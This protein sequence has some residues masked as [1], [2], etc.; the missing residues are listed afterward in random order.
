MNNK[1]MMQKTIITKMETLLLIIIGLHATHSL[2][3]RILHL[4]DE[5]LKGKFIVFS[6]IVH[7]FMRGYRQCIISKV[8]NMAFF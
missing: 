1:A 2:T 6:I 8:F 3:E 7:P 4:K 5:T